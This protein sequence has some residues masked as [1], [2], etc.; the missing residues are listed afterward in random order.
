M[1]MGTL[2]SLAFLKSG[3]VLPA[4][5]LSP[6]TNRSID[7]RM[8]KKTVM[9]LPAAVVLLAGCSNPRSSYTWDDTTLYDGDR[10]IGEVVA[11]HTPDLSADID[12]EPVGDDLYRIIARY[13]AASASD[14]AAFTLDFVTPQ[15]AQWWM[16]PSVS[17]NGNNWGRGLEPRGART[18]GGWYTYTHRITPIPGI[19]YAESADY[20]VAFWAEAP[21][22]DRENFSCSIMPDTLSTTHRLMWPEEEMPV[23]Y[24]AR[25]K[26]T[27]GYRVPGRVAQGDTLTM[28]AYLSVAPVQPGHRAQHKFLTEAW[29]MAEK[30]RA[31][32]HTPAEL[33]E[34]G[35]QY[36]ESWLYSEEG[37]FAGFTIGYSPDENN[38]LQRRRGYEIGWCGQNASFANSMLTDY[39]RHGNEA[40]RDMGMKVLDSWAALAPQPG[41]LFVTNYDRVIGLDAIPSDIVFD[42]CNL[43]TAAL[44]Y[45]EAADLAK[46]CGFERDN[47]TR[48]AY[49]ICDF[50]RADQQ[51]SGVYGRG[52]HPDGTCYVR[53]GTIGA[54]MVPPMLEAYTRSSD[55]AYLESGRRAYDY[56]LS[57]LKADGYTTAGALDTW[58]IDKES[59]I[60]LIRGAMRLY[61]ITGDKKYIDDAVAI[62]DYLSTWLWH[63][64]THFDDPAND[65][66]K[67]GY[68]TFGAT[69]VSTQHRHLDPYAVFWVPEWFE[70]SE[71]TGDPQWAGKAVAVWENASQLVSDG[72][73]V[74]NGVL[75]P[76]GSQNEA[77]FPSRWHWTGEEPAERLNQWLVAWPG[78]FRLETIRRLGA[79]DWTSMPQ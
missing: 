9:W 11:S 76:A 21:A 18:D 30:P 40:R 19:T 53:E 4:S 77:F 7:L 68:H 44:N 57:Q 61:K 42:A 74:I 17:Y 51:E 8:I 12:I 15:Q 34:Y 41:G 29:D 60:S 56:Y 5:V 52:W 32:I 46:A 25:D 72:N 35:L 16:I 38:V 79:A 39:L 13:V 59:S 20:A 26:Y 67:Y 55:E 47:F 65:F 3:F 45:F 58:C 73:L 2:S 49:D 64:D 48:I 31:D 14:S 24:C 27:D 69:S 71:I 22:A 1:L 70:L 66:N 23:L 10:I 37:D 28:T 62:S 36:A 75:R 54:F 6:T 33:W 63:Y 43:G 78:A 50:V